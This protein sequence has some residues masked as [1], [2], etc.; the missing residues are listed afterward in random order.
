MD[1]SLSHIADRVASTFNKT[2]MTK[3]RVGQSNSPSIC[4]PFVEEVM[5]KTYA[6]KHDILNIQCRAREM[7]E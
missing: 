7:E 1:V 4:R 3:V 2:R 5:G 6:I